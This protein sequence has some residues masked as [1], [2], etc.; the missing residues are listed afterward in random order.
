MQ[1]QRRAWKTF[2]RYHVGSFVVRTCIVTVV[3]LSL[4]GMTPQ[5][6]VENDDVQAFTT[7]SKD[8]STH[9]VIGNNAPGKPSSH[10]DGHAGMAVPKKQS[11]RFGLGDTDRCLPYE[12][13]QG[14]L[15]ATAGTAVVQAISARPAEPAQPR[16]PAT[17]AVARKRAHPARTITMAMPAAVMSA[18]ASSTSGIAKKSDAIAPVLS[19]SSGAQNVFPPGQCTWW[20]DQRYYQLH[21]VFVPW[22][23]NANAGQWSM[24]ALEFGWH[25]SSTPTLGAIIVLQG[26]VQG[27]YSLGHVG[28]VEQIQSD[29]TVIASSLNWGYHSGVTNTQFRPGPG[30]T[31]LSQ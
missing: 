20:A 10:A 18:S 7:C 31:F 11:A 2:Q 25:V 27:A 24:R 6:H 15:E 9:P 4:I 21:G 30:V 16:Q 12:L 29:G 13:A 14:L 3:G 22:T 1:T 5:W 28:V 23:N 8:E 17:R 19:A 26:G